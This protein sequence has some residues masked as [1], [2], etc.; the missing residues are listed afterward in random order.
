MT[1]SAAEAIHWTASTEI[2]SAGTTSDATAAA[3][4]KT[5]AVGT[6]QRLT[7]RRPYK[8]SLPFA[9]WRHNSEGKTVLADA[10]ALPHPALWPRRR[11]GGLRSR[12]RERRWAARTARSGGDRRRER[13][14]RP[15][16][17]TDGQGQARRERLRPR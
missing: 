11:P 7:A 13:H 8:N 2:E 9:H 4:R 1:T 5:A 16:L 17:G 14:A 10:P 12:G 3:I 15:A 6:F